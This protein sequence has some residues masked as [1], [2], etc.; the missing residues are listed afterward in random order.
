MPF[1]PEDSLPRV[2]EALDAE[3]GTLRRPPTTATPLR[4]L[5]IPA[6]PPDHR[7]PTRLAVVA[8]DAGNLELRL[9][10][11]RIGLVRIATSSPLGLRA[12]AFVPLSL[13]A[14]EQLRWVFKEPTLQPLRDAAITCGLDPATAETWL[15]S[16]MQAEYSLHFLRELLEWLLLAHAAATAPPGTVLLR[17]GLLRSVA[18]PRAAFEPI[19]KALRRLTT[20][21]D[22]FLCALA[23]RAPG[24]T[25]FLHYLEVAIGANLGDDGSG[26][27]TEPTAFEVPPALE[28]Q[29][30]P[31]AF[32]S[33]R[34]RRAGLLFLW[35]ASRTRRGRPLAV[36]IPVWQRRH[37]G[38]LLATLAA[39]GRGGYPEPGYP[40][41]L[42]I[43]HQRARIA[44]IEREAFGRTFLRHLAA[45]RPGLRERLLQSHLTGQGLMFDPEGAGGENE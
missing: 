43:A 31:G 6:L 4:P 16:A 7:A 28:E 38:F 15:P 35:I 40:P 10:P 29:F 1:V 18:I 20:E 22:L 9:H 33:L 45:E 30:S 32:A 26:N 37:A 44:P 12:E 36:E 14:A 34:G 39:H 27:A 25:D 21:R 41:E 24:G 3:L 11:L 5:V 23:K 2:R 19:C 13:P 8:A 17:D 42:L